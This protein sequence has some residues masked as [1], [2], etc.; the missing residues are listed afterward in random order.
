MHFWWETNFGYKK[1][2]YPVQSLNSDIITHKAASA[3]MIC[4]II[5]SLLARNNNKETWKF[6]DTVL[7]K[8]IQNAEHATP[9]LLT[10]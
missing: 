9:I 4:V 3:T 2:Y 6:I 10:V 5:V 8:K 1:I 7:N